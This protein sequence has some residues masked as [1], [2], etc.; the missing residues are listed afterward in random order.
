MTDN[1]QAEDYRI[2]LDLL[3]LNVPKTNE[4][5]GRIF[6]FV[7]CEYDRYKRLDEENKRLREE[8]NVCRYNRDLLVNGLKSMLEKKK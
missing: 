8:L 3:G 4:D 5:R 2:I 7:K 6:Q 1:I